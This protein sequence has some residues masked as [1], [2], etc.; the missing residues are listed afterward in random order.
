MALIESNAIAG[1]SIYGVQQKDY[2]VKGEANCDYLKAASVAMFQEANAIEA[3]TAA[4]AA[5]LEARQ[6]KL[7]ELSE[8]LATIVTA[9]A[10]MK[11]KHQKSSDL[12]DADPK[13]KTASEILERYY[14][15]ANSDLKLSVNKDNKVRRDDAT[16][17]QSAVQYEIDY[18]T[19]EMQQ[20]MVSLQS[21][22]SK[23]DNAFST[24]ASLVQKITST[25]SALI[26]NL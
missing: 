3:E 26:N 6:Q 13:L 12:S 18:E 23:R 24:V 7:D 21:L 19:N 4:Y 1:L 2:T 10:S 25:S 17:A 15:D 14:R 9:I 8:A 5:V 20:D 16:K 22:V 11:V